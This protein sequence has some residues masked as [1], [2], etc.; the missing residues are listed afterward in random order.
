MTVGDVV[1]CILVS[2]SRLLPKIAFKI[3]AKIQ[4]FVGKLPF[5]Q[6]RRN[7][8]AL[9]TKYWVITCGLKAFCVW[10]RYKFSKTYAWWHHKFSSVKSSFPREPIVTSSFHNR[11][12]RKKQSQIIHFINIRERILLSLQLWT[13][14]YIRVYMNSMDVSWCS[15]SEAAYNSMLFLKKLKYGFF[16]CLIRP[17]ISMRKCSR[18]G[19]LLTTLIILHVEPPTTYFSPTVFKI[20]VMSNLIAI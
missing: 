16:F 18:F 5:V 7:F 15:L 11:C 13:W 1:Y 3:F 10:W 8:K 19:W 12:Q 2:C 4:L 17:I 6:P 20:D 9:E 14:W